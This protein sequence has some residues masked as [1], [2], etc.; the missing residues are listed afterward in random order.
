MKSLVL[1]F[2]PETGDTVLITGHARRRMR[3]RVGYTFDEGAWAKAAA[4]YLSNRLEPYR[5]QRARGEEMARAYTLRVRRGD[6]VHHIPVVF[7]KGRPGY[8]PAVLTCYEVK[9]SRQ[10]D[11]S[12]ADVEI[13]QD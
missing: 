5:Q 11:G 13:V 1:R 8:G 2:G 10:W 7:G 6:T 9:E 4:L 3:S 12:N